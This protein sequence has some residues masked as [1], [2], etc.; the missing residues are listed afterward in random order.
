MQKNILFFLG[1]TACFIGVHAAEEGWE[2]IGKEQPIEE[3]EGW[4]QVPDVPSSIVDRYA[5]VNLQFTL[6]P[7]TT[8]Q[9]KTYAMVVRA[10]QENRDVDPMHKD[11]IKN[12]ST[13]FFNKNYTLTE[14]TSA[15][16]IFYWVIESFN[17]IETTAFTYA[18]YP[19]R[20][21]QVTFLNRLVPM[22]NP[23]VMFNTPT[24]RLDQGDFAWPKAKKQFAQTIADT[25]YEYCRSYN[26]F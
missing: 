9:S 15:Q 17:W 24:V 16:E 14:T 4:V 20:N 11:Y 6:H 19:L 2:I 25:I 7:K 10:T 22:K 12:S 3:E 13:A 5:F 1:L 26:I 21:L 23:K 18:G 8:G